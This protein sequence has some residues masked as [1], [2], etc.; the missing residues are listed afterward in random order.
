MTS[1]NKRQKT[2]T[3]KDTIILRANDMYKIFDSTIT[4][5]YRMFLLMNLV[6]DAGVHPSYYGSLKNNYKSP[7]SIAQRELKNEKFMVRVNEIKK[8]AQDVKTMEDIEQIKENLDSAMFNGEKITRNLQIIQNISY[9]KC[10]FE[11]VWELVN[12]GLLIVKDNNVIEGLR[13]MKSASDLVPE[14]KEI[15]QSIDII[16]TMCE[17]I[18]AIRKSCLTDARK[19][20]GITCENKCVNL[21]NITHS[22]SERIDR[23]CLSGRKSRPVPGVLIK[24]KPDG[25][26]GDDVVEIKFRSAVIPSQNSYRIGELLQMHCYMHSLERTSCWMLE[27]VSSKLGMII[28][29]RKVLFDQVLWSKVVALT[30]KLMEFVTQLRN[31]EFFLLAFHSMSDEVKIEMFEDKVGSIN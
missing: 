20:Y 25:F 29:R 14:C 7:V 10:H 6:R 15:V 2:Y 13:L 27:C 12:N 11:L 5:G 9:R 16:V 17:H 18:V 19:N 26:I 1:T 8:E 28:E 3:N 30:S 4:P 31:H 22:R 23:F 21:W 24:C